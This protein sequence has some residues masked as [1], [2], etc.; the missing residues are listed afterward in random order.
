MYIPFYNKKNNVNEFS[1][2]AFKPKKHCN[3]EDTIFR[4][5]RAVKFEKI[6]RFFL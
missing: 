2:S 5:F 1:I 6:T 4:E 3:E